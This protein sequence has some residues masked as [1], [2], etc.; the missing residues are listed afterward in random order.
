MPNFIAKLVLPGFLL[1]CAAPLA[2]LTQYNQPYWDDYLFAALYRQL[3]LLAS[4]QHYYLHSGGRFS[5]YLL[6]L[7]GNPLSYG[8]VGGVKPI[9]FLVMVGQVASI[10]FALQTFTKRALS[11]GQ[12]GWYSLGLWL[13]FVYTCPDIHSG[14]YWFSSLVVHQLAC[15]LLLIIPAAVVRAQYSVA[16]RR[17]WFLLAVGLTFLF[18]G[19]SELG[20]WLLGLVFLTAMGHSA[21]AKQYEWVKRWGGLLLVLGLGF[22]LVLLAP[23]N[24]ERM[25]SSPKV[26]FTAL[27]LAAQVGHGLRLVM[28]QPVFFA[29]L[30]VPVLFAPLAPRLLP[31][32]PAGLHLPLLT[33]AGILLLGIGGGTAMLSLLISSD[34]LARGVNVLYWW[35]LF[36]WLAACWASLPAD[37]A[38]LPRFSVAVRTL[39]AALL[40]VVFAAPT[41]RAW[42]EALWE[43]P[44]W[45]AQCEVRD[46]LYRSSRNRHSK[47]TVPPITQVTPRYVL[48]RG[49]DIQ[50]YYSHP[51]NISVAQYFHLDSVR[52]DA[53]W[54][55][56]ASF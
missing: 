42:Q 14:L 21:Y 3:G 16:H 54:P 15:C 48:V 43:A 26:A 1:F 56:P 51:L 47:L 2:L 29:L 55:T 52:T 22:S 49:Y 30:V 41:L 19:T 13:V 31:H 28:W 50:P 20:V 7:L 32:R 34:L 45:A 46:G 37:P 6:S 24:Y 36:G 8:W 9:S 10:F 39:V 11:P 25:G 33:S 18:A 53:K 40:V 4:F 23:G 38:Q 27:S 35:T 44:K 17:S 12:A 5:S